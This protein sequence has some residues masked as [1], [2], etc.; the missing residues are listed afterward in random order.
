MS[1]SACDRLRQSKVSP[2]LYRETYR[3]VTTTTPLVTVRGI[4]ITLDK[5]LMRFIAAVTLSTLGRR[6]FPVAGE[7]IIWNDLP[8]HITS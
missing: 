8:S 1:A 2:P 6:T 3:R 5:G 7:C 4:K